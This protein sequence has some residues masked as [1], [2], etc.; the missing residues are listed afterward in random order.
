MSIAQL[1]RQLYGLS[2]FGRLRA[3]FH[4]VRFHPDFTRNSLMRLPLLS[5]ALISALSLST[6]AAAQPAPAAPPLGKV[7]S[8]ER[9]YTSDGAAIGHVE[10]V[11]RAKDGSLKDVGMIYQ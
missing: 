1:Y 5:A 10:Y 11:D 6:I 8:G 2:V 7:K 3:D 4:A 9:V